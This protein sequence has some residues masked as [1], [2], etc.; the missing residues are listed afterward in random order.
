MNSNIA[1]TTSIY[2]SVTPPP[3]DPTKTAPPP[4]P[5]PKEHLPASTSTLPKDIQGAAGQEAPATASGTPAAAHYFGV[6]TAVCAVIILVA[7]ALT[8]YALVR[9]RNA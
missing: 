1:M 4:Q 6:W 7:I 8:L 5:M 3:P 2:A 9:D